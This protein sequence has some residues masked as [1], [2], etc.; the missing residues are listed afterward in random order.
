[1]SDIYILI[2]I[3]IILILLFFILANYFKDKKIMKIGAKGEKIIAKILKRYSIIRGYKVINDIYLPLYE[4]TTQIDH[5]LIGN[6]G[7]LVVETKNLHGEIYGNPSEKNWSQFIGT[8][9]HKF[10]NPIFQN[11][12]H[13]DNIRY[14]FNKENIYNINIDGVVV[15]T[16]NKIVLN[17]PKNKMVYRLKEFKKL[18]KKDRYENNNGVDIQKIYDSIIKY[19]V[20]D[21]KKISAHKRNVN[22]N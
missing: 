9:K 14:I 11:K 12:T 8:K 18:L 21:S 13:I 15:F 3:L 7:V 4:E 6:F 16:G 5:I 10:Y 19:K 1:M 20:T 22:K 2:I 17:I